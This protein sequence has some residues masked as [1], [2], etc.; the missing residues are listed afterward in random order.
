MACDL[1]VSS[2]GVQVELKAHGEILGQLLA[3]NITKDESDEEFKKLLLQRVS[4]IEIFIAIAKLVGGLIIILLIPFLTWVA[5]SILESKVND[6]K[7]I[8]PAIIKEKTVK[9]KSKEKAE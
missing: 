9:T 7:E 6:A 3:R 2:K 8:P 1:R 4:Q 5:L